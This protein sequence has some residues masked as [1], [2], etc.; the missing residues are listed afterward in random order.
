MWRKASQHKQR[1][2]GGRGGRRKRKH[3]ST[4]YMLLENQKE[5][6]YF[7]K[8]P[9]LSPYFSYGGKLAVDED[10]VN[11]VTTPFPNTSLGPTELAGVAAGVF[12]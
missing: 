2:W 6:N 9:A 5:K 11:G 12:A 10:G 3:Y 7:I 4:G 1:G 8:K